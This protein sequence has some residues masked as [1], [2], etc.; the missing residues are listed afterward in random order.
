MRL[1]LAVNVQINSFNSE[2]LSSIY[3]NDMQS[4]ILIYIRKCAC[5]NTYTH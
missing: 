3:S 1:M 4:P 5:A 2:L